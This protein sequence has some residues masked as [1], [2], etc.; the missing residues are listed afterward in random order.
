MLKYLNVYIIAN[1]P[2]V[3]YRFSV[4]Y[5]PKVVKYRFFKMWKITNVP[6][7]IFFDEKR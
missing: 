1:K 6:L 2:F 7:L 4:F 3:I 5:I